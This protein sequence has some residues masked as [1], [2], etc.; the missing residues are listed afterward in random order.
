LISS[1]VFLRSYSGGIPYLSQAWRERGD[2]IIGPL[3]FPGLKFSIVIFFFDA[4]FSLE[5]DQGG[6]I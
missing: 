3:F 6:V 4:M 1:L 2:V 5:S